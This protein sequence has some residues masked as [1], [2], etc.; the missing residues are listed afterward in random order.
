MDNNKDI[1]IDF[2]QFNEILKYFKNKNKEYKFINTI[3]SNNIKIAI[4]ILFPNLNNQDYEVLILFT[5]NIIEKISNYN[6]FDNDFDKDD[7]YYKQWTQ[8]KYRDI[9]GIVMI[10]LPFI[11]DGNDGIL[12][13]SMIDL[14]QF[15][16]GHLQSTIP[17]LSSENRTDILKSDFKFSNMSLGL[18]NKTSK[19]D[20][21]KLY[22][23]DG[24]MKLIYKII[25]HNYL[26][27][28]RTLQIMNGKYYQNWINIVPILYKDS[29]NKELPNDL[30]FKQSKLYKKTDEGLKK[31]QEDKLLSDTDK[32]YNF[33]K[34]DYYG[35]YL[36]DIYN[37]IKIKMYDEIKH[38]KWLIFPQQSKDGNIYIIQHLGNKIKFNMFF[39][40]SNYEDV[41][42]DDK[43]KFNKFIKNTSNILQKKDIEMWKQILLFL[44][45]N[46][47][48]KLIVKKE[49]IKEKKDKLYNKFYL[50]SIEFDN[51][52]SVENN[53]Y[54][55]PVSE[56]IINIKSCD[57]IEYLSIIN[58]KHIWNFLYETIALFNNTYLRDYFI[59]ENKITK[60]KQI[61]TINKTCDGYY[62][63]GTKLSFKNIYN[64]AKSI[65][66]YNDDNNTWTS[67]DSHSIS[68]PI[69]QEIEFLERFSSNKD[70]NK[71]LNLTYNLK[72]EFNIIDDEKYKKKMEE[73]NKNWNEIKL[74]LVF[75]ILTKNGILSEFDVALDITDKNN[76]DSSRS[77][78]VQTLKKM[79]KRMDNNKKW[80]NAYY[81]LTNNKY[82]NLEKTLLEDTK[83][84]VKKDH[85]YF[86][87]FSKNQLWYSFYA[88]DWLS[89]INF[90]HHYIHHR[91]LYVTGATGTGKSTQ[92][93]KLLMYALKA[94]E[95][96]NN[97][98]VVC[99]QP[100]ITPTKSNAER[101][102]EEL[103]VPIVRPLKK[104]QDTEKTDN[105][106]VQ[107]KYSTDYH[108][109]NNCS[110]TTL[111][112]LTDGTLYDELQ[113]N[114][115]MKEQIYD[116]EKKEFIY[117]YKNHYDIIILDES[118]E[119]NTNMDMILTLTRQSCL[120]NNSLRLIIVSAT[121]SEDEPIYRSYFRCINDDLVYPIKAPMYKHPILTNLFNINTCVPD[122]IYMDRRFHISPPGE[123]TQYIVS[124]IYNNNVQI[125]G[126]TDKEISE[127]TQ[128]ESYKTIL[129]ICQ[130]YPKGDILL[131]LTGSR[132]INEAVEYL[133]QILPQGDIA[134]P[135]YA[136]LH[137]K[138][139]YI[140][141]KIH[142]KI[143]TIKNKRE[144][145]HIEWSE[146]YIED[147]SVPNGIY[148]R[149]IIIATNVAEASITIDSLKFIVDTG[150]SKVNLFNNEYG[151]T[152]L[153]IEP[154][155]EASRIQRK[156][157]IGRVSNGIAYFVYSKGSREKIQPKYKI[158][159]EDNTNMY[160]KLLKTNNINDED[161]IILDIYDPNDYDSSF[162]NNDLL[163]II[164]NTDKDMDK[165]MDK[166][167]VFNILK[168]QYSIKNKIVDSDLY[169]NKQYYPK[170][171]I[172][173]KCLKRIYSGQY[174]T[175]LSDNTGEFYI[176]HPKENFIVRNIN[177]EIIYYNKSKLNSIPNHVFTKEIEISQQKLIVIDTNYSSNIFNNDNKPNFVKTDI[178][179]KVND[180]KK[181]LDDNSLDENDYLTIFAAIG[182]DC[183]Y[184]VL[185]ILILIK[186][187]NGSISELINDNKLHKFNNIWYSNISSKSEIFILNN[188]YEKLKSDNRN[189]YIF[190]IIENPKIL[191]EKTTEIDKQ[192]EDFKEK[193]NLKLT[194][195][196]K[197]IDD[198]HNWNLM[199]K[200]FN[201]GKLENK[202]GQEI[203][204]ED[205]LIKQIEKDLDLNNL[206][207]KLW[208]ENY[209][210]KYEHIKKYLSTLSKLI[211]N[212][213]TIDKNIDD[214]YGE[215]SPLL[216]VDNIK[217]NFLKVLKTN[218]IKEKII[219]SFIL[220]RP[221]NY[222]IKLDFKNDYYNL[223]SPDLK[224]YLNINKLLP[225]YFSNI[226]F[227]YNYVDI[228]G[229]LNLNLVNDIDIDY[230]T[231][232]LPH[233]FNKKKFKKIRPSLTYEY[234]KDC[235]LEHKSFMQINGSNYDQIVCFINN[236]SMGLSPWEND[237]MPEI[238]NFFKKLR[239]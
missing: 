196:N 186:T 134:I 20:L 90:F 136:D 164:N 225:V 36:G 172:T 123:T 169:W 214:E 228:K 95:M 105:F 89:Q 220:G 210:I 100:R 144:R 142:I 1:N 59:E 125:N 195:D 40:Y 128:E 229:K 166:K 104:G 3:L 176:I 91:V 38:I 106:Y 6:D 175:S 200:L 219:K 2:N 183:L 224:G 71:W 147:P 98:K 29:C 37:T 122:T 42:I 187:V 160:L 24:E 139:K 62:Y 32:Y 110:H 35:L 218:N 21:L 174:I 53:E 193:Y 138:Y 189:L 113:S 227:Y 14:N 119:H 211:I 124:E 25:H 54:I 199:K 50:K 43:N 120:Y 204:R 222:G 16:Y 171:I 47:S 5:E 51:L 68:F 231:S 10:L 58:V 28:I 140:V 161:V 22:E 60:E 238:S 143:Y 184:E 48:K 76:Y 197:D 135:F 194:G 86:D 165:D 150:Y 185:S 52:D 70:S 87:L 7:K 152:Q 148:K 149:A 216:W 75:E 213:L 237:K 99:T 236:N 46:Y 118:H 170:S 103:G 64:I 63:P 182:F 212:L 233:I 115:M 132:E 202:S 66:H 56:K 117:G 73:I 234:K 39:K 235:I 92:V 93:P 85:D 207:I 209:F 84:H 31:L 198:I 153:H 179:D 30:S 72:K 12:L 8:N 159:Q 74:D 121:M 223:Y 217:H 191:K 41:N 129:Q 127:L 180:L 230:F 9:K 192:I 145:V 221:L 201:F 18:L 111:K 133:N 154:I 178:Y 55:E 34:D 177:N 82:E 77:S 126:L 15:L 108:L 155:A 4:E 13:N 88:M 208:C 151:L 83:T 215:I 206:K 232:C 163:E 61:I 205:I 57:I 158:T 188:I 49:L 181:A 114:P 67:Y 157:R 109:K 239:I 17:D 94:Y 190:K 79:E 33:I 102:S 45:N 69:E 65:T 203:L 101:I 141:E 112:I 162:Y 80:K 23:K 146:N 97:G 27:L 116:S 131:F 156:G 26:G 226:I 44:T 168:K 167:N 78:R 19:T 11:D 137:D 130:K 107:M 81:Y 96:K 173:N